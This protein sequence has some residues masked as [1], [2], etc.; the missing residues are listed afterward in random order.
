M[1]RCS[2][3]CAFAAQVLSSC[4]QNSLV[5][6]LGLLAFFAQ[7]V[8]PVPD[9]IAD[10]TRSY[11]IACRPV[12]PKLVMPPRI[13][14][15]EPFGVNVACKTLPL[16]QMQKGIF[17]WCPCVSLQLFELLHLEIQPGSKKTLQCNGFTTYGA[18]SGSCVLS[19]Q[20]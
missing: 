1:L 3:I 9:V 7:A 2:E 15:P 11:A 18:P 13:A 16:H 8:L 20:Q 6:C 17:V 19:W 12:L 14:W 10:S 5:G 4:A